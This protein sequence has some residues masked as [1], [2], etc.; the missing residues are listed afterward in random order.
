MS[1]RRNTTRRKAFLGA[2][3]VF[4]NGFQ[5]YD[6]LVLNMSDTGAEINTSGALIPDVFDLQIPHRNRSYR[7]KVCW[8]KDEWIGVQFIESLAAAS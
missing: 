3:A 1:E 8:R 5:S 4:A 6:C 2:K 7:A